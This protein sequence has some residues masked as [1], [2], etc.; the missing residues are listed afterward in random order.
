VSVIGVYSG[1]ADKFPIGSLMN[2]SLTIKSGQC[3]VHRYMKPLL[4]HI[5][6]GRIDPTFV[7]SHTMKL[8]DAPVGFDIF[9]HKDDACT[10]IVLKP[11]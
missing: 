9:T 11:N 5:Q 10:K 8:D 1:L 3:H 2:R 7:I 4:E 6:A